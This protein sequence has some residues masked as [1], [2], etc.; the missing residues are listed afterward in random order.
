M[1]LFYRLSAD[2]IVLIHFAYVSFVI[3][4]LIAILA[5]WV[6][7]WKWTR[8]TTFRVTHLL[9]IAIVVGE[10]LCGITCPSNRF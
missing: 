8:N 6:L 4:G 5:G 9:A 3:V 1:Q 2:L 10:A 7:R